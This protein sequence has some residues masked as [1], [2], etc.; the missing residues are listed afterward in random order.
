MEGGEWN[1]PTWSWSCC[2]T[3]EKCTFLHEKGYCDSCASSRWGWGAL[4]LE[5][6]IQTYMMKLPKHAGMVEWTEFFY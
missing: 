5:Q 1:R 2:T 4:T 3:Q 6:T